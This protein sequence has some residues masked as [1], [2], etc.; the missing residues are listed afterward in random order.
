MKR[1]IAATMVIALTGCAATQSGAYFRPIT[2]LKGKDVTAYENDLREC[3]AYATQVPGAGERA[4][5]GTGFGALFGALIVAAA[6]KK[7]YR[8]E[9]A[10]V[11]AL[12]GAASG[13]VEGEREQRKIITTCLTNRGYSVLNA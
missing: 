13:A 9:G 11:G 1:V 7:G 3:Q 6:G 12:S 5:A 10:A 2:D 4:V 8:N